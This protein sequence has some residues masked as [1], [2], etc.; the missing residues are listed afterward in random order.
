MKRTHFL[1]AAIFL[2]FVLS[3]CDDF[4]N[5]E[6]PE[7]ISIKSEGARYAFPLGNMNI[8]L[9]ENVNVSKIHEVLA[10]NMDGENAIQV[11]DYN[12][13][14]SDNSVLTYI[15][16]YDIA[17]IPF[18]IG[19]ADVDSLEFETEFPLPSFNQNVAD[20][21]AIEGKTLPM[22]ETGTESPIPSDAGVDFNI[23]SP[24]FETMELRSGYLDITLEAPDTV[25]NDFSMMVSVI[26]EDKAGNRI[27]SSG[28]AVECARG[29]TFSL[30]LRGK[31]LV[32]NMFIRVS[33]TLSGGTQGNLNTYTVSMAPREIQLAKITGLTMSNDELGGDGRIDV[34]E[35]FMM[36]G[37]NE[38]LVSAEIKSGSLAFKS[39]LP[40]GWSG[41]K[42]ESTFVLGG[43]LAVSAEKFTD[44]NT[45][46]SL[47]DKTADLSGATL[48]PTEE[49]ST[50]GSVVEISLENATIVFNDGDTAI[51]L[52]GKMNIDEIERIV[53][54]FDS[55]DSLNDSIDTGINC[56]TLITD[57]LEGKDEGLLD[58]VFFKGIEGY[59]FVTSPDSGA[60][61]DAL[62]DIGIEGTVRAEYTANGVPKNL[63]LAGS[64]AADEMMS[65]KST[66]KTL[67]SLAD[68][69]YMITSSELFDEHEDDLQNRYS[70]KMSSEEMCGLLND[71]PD[72]LMLYY[73]MHLTGAGDDK[74]ITIENVD[75]DELGDNISIR[76]SIALIIPLELEF[77]DISDGVDD[78]F[79]TIDDV[80]ALAGQEFT[81]DLLERD[82]AADSEDWLDYTDLIKEISLGYKIGNTTPLD[83][84]EIQFVDELS[85]ID[86]KIET[87]DG[88][89][90]LTL[91]KEDA[92]SVI[93]NHP[94]LPY[95]RMKIKAGDYAF[96]RDAEFSMNGTISVETGGQIE[97]W[98][99]NEE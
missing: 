31:S 58:N 11:Y 94:F 97:I 63:Y 91:T 61:S 40:D 39:S 14:K 95:I 69:K 99:K 10:E 84:L 59:V 32:P 2:S 73:D 6:I 76:A 93:R 47:I 48:I 7:S 50:N 74:T 79:I 51:S 19:D 18:S 17:E 36:S 9:L 20:N 27:S 43:G 98:N 54:K 88:E 62:K 75:F 16:D 23:T 53:V 13:E 8:S 67:A 35:S 28:E 30:D 80:L 70:F 82:S 21:L 1:P 85:G 66:S 86:E 71:K 49:I 57:F 41:V 42:C 34:D 12:P 55:L 90:K 96:K 45:E 68:E 38:Y 89:H 33:G 5:L 26:L 22:V 29:N 56:S 64:E 78:D 52:E 24:E 46:N 37:V 77:K 15:I 44:G 60:V 81:D 65:I 4:K 25:S 83:G 92:E 72:G 3:G 87:S